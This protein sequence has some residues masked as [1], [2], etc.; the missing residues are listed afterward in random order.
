MITVVMSFSAPDFI[1][2]LVY[3]KNTNNARLVENPFW[4]LNSISYE[5][6]YLQLKFETLFWA[7][8]GRTFVPLLYSNF[9]SINKYC[10]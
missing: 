4:R 2:I 7:S 8:G 3:L 6:W 9:T 10:T 5:S 1:Y